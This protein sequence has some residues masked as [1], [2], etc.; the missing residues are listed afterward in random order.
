MAKTWYP[1][2]DYEKCIGCLTC[3]NFCPH[4][5]YTVENGKPKVVNP[6]NCVEFCR[7]CQKLCPT[8][9]ITYNGDKL[10]RN[11]ARYSQQ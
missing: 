8:G 9:A 11:I 2:I 5:V 3:V 4:E 6:D 10:H 1:V 7:G